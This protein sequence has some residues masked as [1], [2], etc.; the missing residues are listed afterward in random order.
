MSETATEPENK[1]GS[2]ETTAAQAETT[3]TETQ[4]GTTEAAADEEEAFKFEE[5]GS[6][7]GEG[8]TGAT[9]A[10]ANQNTVPESKYNEAI[11]ENG[12]LKTQLAEIQARITHPIVEKAMEAVAVSDQVNPAE[13]LRA[14]FG[15]AAE[16]LSVEEV[17]KQNLIND[18]KALKIT[19]SEDQLEEDYNLEVARLETLGTTGKAKEIGKMRNVIRED[20][21]QKMTLLVQAKQEDADKGQKIIADSINAIVAKMTEYVQAGKKTEGLIGE[22][23]KQEFELCSAA[24]ENGFLRY[25]SKGNLDVDHTI[26]IAQFA[27]DKK[28]YI[29]TLYTKWKRK[30]D[31]EELIARSTGSTTSPTT[32][33]PADQEKPAGANK[34]H[35]EPGAWNP[36]PLKTQKATAN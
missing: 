6:T 23:T 27:S 34:N 19:L 15:I 4:T 28:K 9:T 3:T 10:S 18:A 36:T 26:E 29:N 17:I 30:R 1:T 14:T 25:D 24:M 22:F 33:L 16:S 35:L 21:A 12:R 20:E 11:Q 7:T 8:A 5:E 32:V 2:A 13:Y 31:A